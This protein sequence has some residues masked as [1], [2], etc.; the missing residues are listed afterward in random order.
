[1]PDYEPDLATAREDLCRFLSA[2]WC[3]PEPA[4]AEE[5][6]FD[7]ILAAARRIDPDLEDAARRLGAAF[8]EQDLQTLLVDYTRLFLGPVQPRAIAYGSTWLSGEDALMQ[9]STM[10]VLAL[11]REGGFATGDEFQDLPDHVAVELEFL[12]LL[13]FKRN[14]AQREGRDADAAAAESLQRRFLREHLGAWIGRFADA[15][16]A[17]AETAFYRELAA[18]T[19]RFVGMRVASK[20]C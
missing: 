16:Q 13:T 1:M 2:C 9:G 18:L 17:G 8:A 11:Y 15:V 6:L 3:Q 10:A 12:Y 4:F 7:S 20:P 5:R 19:S 14:Q